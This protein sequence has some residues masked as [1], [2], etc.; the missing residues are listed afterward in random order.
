MIE[1]T[2]I[3]QNVVEDFS[4]K[5]TYE[6]IEEKTHSLSAGQYFEVKIIFSELTPEEFTEK[7][8]SFTNKL[9]QL[10]ISGQKYEET[11]KNKLEGLKYE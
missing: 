1:D 8:S 3:N 11:I 2:F 9:E 5:V 4:V 7:I 6:Q 10:F